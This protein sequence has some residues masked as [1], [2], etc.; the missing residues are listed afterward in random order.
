MSRRIM[1]AECVEYPWW[2]IIDPAR[3]SLPHPSDVLD[4]EALEGADYRH[5]IKS[6]DFVGIITGP[7]F[8]RVGAESYLTA[9]RHNYSDR[10]LVWCMSGHASA[11]WRRFCEVTP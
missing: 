4:A 3:A 1:P 8:S 2:V 5:D 6:G 10:A 7:F 9:N 11:E